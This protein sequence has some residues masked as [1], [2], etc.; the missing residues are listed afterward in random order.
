MSLSLNSRFMHHSPARPTITNIILE[1]TEACP[2]NIAPTRS[3]RNKPIKSQFKAPI[4][5]STSENL[6]NF[7]QLLFVYTDFNVSGIYFSFSMYNVFKH[8]NISK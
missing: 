4:I 8:G 7:I 5:T 3:N 6:F 2:P 1:I